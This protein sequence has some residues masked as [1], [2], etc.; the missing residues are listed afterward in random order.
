MCP[1]VGIRRAL[2]AWAAV[3]AASPGMVLAALPPGRPYVLTIKGENT[4]TFAPE[5]GL[6]PLPIDYKA[7]IEYLVNTR[8]IKRAADTEPAAGKKARPRSKRRAGRDARPPG[9]DVPGAAGA[10]DLALHSAEM[11]LRQREQMVVQ[12]RISRAGFQGRLLPGAPVMTVTYNQA[13][14][15]LLGLLET[16]DTTAASIVLDDGANVLA[17]RG[18]GEGPLH[19]IIETLLSIHTPI[20]KDVGAWEAPTQLAMGHG[21]TAQGTLRFEKEKG[22]APAIGGPIRVKVS[23]VLKAEGAI[24]GNLIKDGTYTVTGEQTYDPR[25]REWTSAKW[26]VAIETELANQGATI[27]HGR[28]KMLVEARPFE[29]RPAARGPAGAKKRAGEKASPGAGNDPG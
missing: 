1:R 22:I 14:P 17:R 21:Q 13:P 8:E 26:S 23:G 11:A 15:A 25:S 6:S 24:V 10:V 28:G 7:R 19:A 5:S 4:I 29:A 2:V 16:F 12:T 18:R 3:L 9:D 27:A 20:P